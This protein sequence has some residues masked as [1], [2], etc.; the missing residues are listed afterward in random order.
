MRNF[1]LRLVIALATFMIGT[2]ATALFN[3][4]RHSSSTTRNAVSRQA[5]ETNIMRTIFRHQI[6]QDSNL[7]RNSY[8][9]SCYNYSD[10]PTKVTTYL[11]AQG[12]PARTLSQLPYSS[13]KPGTATLFLRVGSINWLSDKEV[14]AGGSLRSSAWSTCE[15]RAYLY[16]LVRE[17]GGWKITATETIS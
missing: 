5:E 11:L 7:E 4:F 14:V 9:L 1:I 12:L 8:Y 10:P 16:H 3:S 13:S 17:D 6:E 15:T 2:S